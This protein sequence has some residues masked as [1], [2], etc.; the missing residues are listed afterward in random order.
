MNKSVMIA[1][2][3]GS[4]EVEADVYGNLAVHQH[5]GFDGFISELFVLTYVPTGGMIS[6][7]QDKQNAI[8][9]ARHLAPHFDNVPQKSAPEWKVWQNAVWP[10]LLR[11]KAWEDYLEV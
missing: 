11:L 4:L 5:L 9:A 8:E 1:T 7:W 6:T 3:Q 2:N 10:I